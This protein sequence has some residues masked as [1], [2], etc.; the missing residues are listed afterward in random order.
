MAFF[1]VRVGKKS[2]HLDVKTDGVSN[3]VCF[4]SD[5]SNQRRLE[6]LSPY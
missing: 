3:C 2:H 5:V 1:I 4:L 6:I